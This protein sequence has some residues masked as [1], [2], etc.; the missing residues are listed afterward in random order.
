M[1]NNAHLGRGD[2]DLDPLFTFPHLS[3]VRGCAG[4]AVIQIQPSKDVLRSRRLFGSHPLNV[5]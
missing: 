3:V 2:H 1:F 5:R 4:S